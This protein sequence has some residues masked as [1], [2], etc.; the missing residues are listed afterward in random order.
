[1]TCPKC[2][3]DAWRD[4]IAPKTKT[5]LTFAGEAGFVLFGM[6][7]IAW[8]SVLAAIVAIVCALFAFAVTLRSRQRVCEKCGWTIATRNTGVKP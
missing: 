6:L 4:A 3:A 7:G 5:R 1:M 2:G 8:K